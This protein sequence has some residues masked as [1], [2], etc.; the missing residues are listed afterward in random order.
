MIDK[1]RQPHEKGA[2]FCRPKNVRVV[3][4]DCN[5][6]AFNGCRCTPSRYSGVLCGT[7]GHH[8]RAKGAWVDAAQDVPR[9]ALAA[10]YNK[11]T[12]YWKPPATDVKESAR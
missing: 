12:T 5:Y 9:D 10:M 3:D 7:C 11:G 8:W 1:Q 4:R 6:S 2:C